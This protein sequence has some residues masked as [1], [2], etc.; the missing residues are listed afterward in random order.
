MKPAPRWIV[1]LRVAVTK[2]QID[3]PIRIS[4]FAEPWRHFEFDQEGIWNCQTEIR[5]SVSSFR[6]ERAA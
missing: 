1:E 2:R 4:P 6:K 5:K 3:N